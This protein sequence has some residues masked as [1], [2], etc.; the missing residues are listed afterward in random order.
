MKASVLVDYAKAALA[1]RWGYIWG[2]HGDLWTKAK[3]EQL[4][5]TTD[6]DRESSR[7]YGK[8]WIGHY[9]TDCSGLIYEPCRKRGVSMPHG[10]N[11]MYLDYCKSKG[12]LIS[13]KRQDGKPLLPGTAMFTYN[14]KTKKYGH[15]GLY[16]GDG[17]CIEAKGA[18]YG[19]V[20]SKPERWGYWGELKG[21][22]YDG[23]SES[24]EKQENPEKPAESA[25][26]TLRRGSKG[27]YVTLLQTQLNNRGYDLGHFGVDGDYGRATEAAVKQF[28]KDW[29]LKE[30]GITGP[31]T[32]KFL[33]SSPTNQLYRVTVYH[34]TKTQAE[35]LRSDYPNSSIASE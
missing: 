16:I 35:M 6:P 14:T 13:G 29:G 20:T 5:K 15:V 10:S 30:D 3:Q 23:E 2:T 11:T 31:E 19:V 25:H 24:P 32:W 9:V 21:I 12:K 18:Q 4:E 17:L 7:K 28:Q 8:Q 22:E 27:E 34:L 33:Q 1:D 26:P